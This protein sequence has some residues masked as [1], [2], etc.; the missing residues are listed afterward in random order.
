VQENQPLSLS[1]SKIKVKVLDIPVDF[2][3]NR[4]KGALKRYG[5]ISMLKI[6]KEE[7]EKK[8][9]DI[10]FNNIT[11]DLENTWSIPMGEDMVRI[12]PAD[13]IH[14]ISKRNSSTARLYGIHSNTTATR[15]MSA[16]KHMEAKSVYIPINGK[17]G[18]R[19]NFAII[20]FQ[21]SKSLEKAISSHVELFGCKTWWS[22][23][24]ET[25]TTGINTKKSG[26]SNNSQLFKDMQI[27]NPD[28]FYKNGSSSYTSLKTLPNINYA[29]K[30]EKTLCNSIF[31]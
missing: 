27:N 10:L 21:N 31:S 1:N 24:N 17:T 16:I 8:S 7:K 5:Q 25:K 15:I 28:S 9:A 19:R 22:A 13:H 18:K 30:K 14:L 12:L 2:S 29:P 3:Y 4:I 23:R 26:Y 20:G 6:N 11:L